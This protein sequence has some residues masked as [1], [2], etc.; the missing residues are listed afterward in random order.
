MK[1]VSTSFV[2]SV[3][4]GLPNI[5]AGITSYEN[6]FYGAYGALSASGRNGAANYHKEGSTNNMIGPTKFNASKS[7]SIYGSSN[8]VTPLSLSCTVLIRY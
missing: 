6:A 7:H 3:S 5:T 4:A 8:T 1:V 2:I